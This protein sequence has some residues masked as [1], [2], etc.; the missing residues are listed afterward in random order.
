MIYYLTNLYIYALF[1]SQEHVIL[2]KEAKFA[3]RACYYQFYNRIGSKKG[4]KMLD[5]NIIIVDN[6]LY[7]SFSILIHIVEA[8]FQNKSIDMSGCLKATVTCDRRLK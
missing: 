2:W 5:N 8:I 1:I 6:K 3:M 4:L 7:H